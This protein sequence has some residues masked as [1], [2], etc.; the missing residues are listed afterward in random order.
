MKIAILS[1]V[2]G[3]L[4]ALDAVLDDLS[5]VAPDRVILNGDII[6]RGPDSIGVMRRL[7]QALPAATRLQG[8]HEA[9]VLRC[10]ASDAPRSGPSYETQQFAYWTADQINGMLSEVGTWEHELDLR[11]EDDAHIHFTH[12]SCLGNRDG[13]HP[14]VPDR[15][16]RAK[17]GDNQDLFIASHTHIPMNRIF[18]GV[19]I[20]NSGSVGAPFDGDPR[21]SYAVICR[22]AGDWQVENRRVAYDRQDIFDAYEETGF[23]TGGGPLARLMRRELEIC[24]GLMGP[25]NRGFRQA[26]L[27]GEISLAESVERTLARSY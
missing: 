27:D 9:W 2:H 1:D 5:V 7:Q 21:A 20:V 25:W 11:L 6:N 19:R 4:A 16:L 3:N 22:V 12:G 23:D 24:R 18:D 10:A 17:I 8:N 13:I 14:R 26:V 15:D